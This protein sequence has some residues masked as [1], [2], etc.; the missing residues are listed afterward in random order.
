MTKADIAH[1]LRKRHEDH[2]HSAEF[3]A[4]LKDAGLV[5]DSELAARYEGLPDDDVIVAHT[6]CQK[7][8]RFP[9]DAEIARAVA[10]SRDADKFLARYMDDCDTCAG[11]GADFPTEL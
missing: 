5:F 3:R 11:C 2:C 10:E 8:G 4:A 9:T 7:C 1:Q 6:T